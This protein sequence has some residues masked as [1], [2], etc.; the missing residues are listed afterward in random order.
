MRNL[1]IGVLRLVTGVCGPGSPGHRN[2]LYPLQQVFLWLR[3]KY[4]YM[5][6]T[7]YEH[8]FLVELDLVAGDL[9]QDLEPIYESIDIQK[10]PWDFMVGPP[11]P[12]LWKCTS[13]MPADFEQIYRDHVTAGL[14]PGQPNAARQP[15]Q[16]RRTAAGTEAEVALNARMWAKAEEAA[17]EKK[18]RQRRLSRLPSA[19][20]TGEVAASASAAS[21]STAAAAPA[22]PLAPAPPPVAVDRQGKA[23]RALP[24]VP[25]ASYI[26]T[27]DPAVSFHPALLGVVVDANGRRQA[28]LFGRTAG[29]S[30]ENADFEVSDADLAITL[31]LEEQHRRDKNRSEARGVF[32]SSVELDFGDLQLELSAAEVAFIAEHGRLEPR[33]QAHIK[34]RLAH[35]AKIAE[36]KK[37]KENKTPEFESSPE[38]TDAELAFFLQVEEGRKKAELTADA[39]IERAR[40]TDGGA[41]G[42]VFETPTKKP[43]NH[44]PESSSQGAKRAVLADVSPGSPPWSPNR[45]P[46]ELKREL[47]L[48]LHG[49]SCALRER[50]AAASPAPTA[51][52]A[53]ASPALQA[54]RAA[55]AVAKAQSPSSAVCAPPFLLPLRCVLPLFYLPLLWHAAFTPRRR[56]WP[57]GSVTRPSS[58]WIATTSRRSLT[59]TSGR[60]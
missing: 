40:R 26:K 55:R 5:N 12:N 39:A 8:Q 28:G 7:P 31:A 20:T 54:K 24:A 21:A 22:P 37:N 51:A 44:D 19:A 47:Q 6:V 18:K 52:A 46:A 4:G 50:R 9:P 2:T 3:Y 53:G 15:R 60:S 34:S 42:P 49:P 58:S 57:G 48:E 43:T 59:P 30:P 14:F 10:E 35:D 1:L 38:F 17:E 16:P 29:P 36:N 11:L 27:T 45:T 23:T 25:A 41:G 33:F 32:S 13:T 56:P